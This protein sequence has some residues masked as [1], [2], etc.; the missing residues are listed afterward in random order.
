MSLTFLSS[1]PQSKN[2][3]P[4]ITK[5]NWGEKWDG[6]KNN[7][8]YSLQ[9]CQLFLKKIATTC[10]GPV[11]THFAR[12]ALRFCEY[13]EQNSERV[14]SVCKQVCF[15]CTRSIFVCQHPNT[16]LVCK[17]KTGQ[18]GAQFELS[19]PSRSNWYL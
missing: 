13:L 1:T 19:H 8:Y 10:T 9:G 4:P 17:S 14:D 3:I 15:Y 18:C 11:R 6:V 5:S 12:L 2:V 7:G 16:N